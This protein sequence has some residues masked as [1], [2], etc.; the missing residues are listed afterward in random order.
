MK[1]TIKEQ[2]FNCLQSLP[3]VAVLSQYIFRSVVA[4]LVW[5][6]YARNCRAGKFRSIYKTLSE[7][8]QRVVKENSRE[9]L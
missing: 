5:M 8:L 3:I 9:L 7:M 6:H 2:I 4:S 1:S